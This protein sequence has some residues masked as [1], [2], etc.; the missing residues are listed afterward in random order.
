MP[1]GGAPSDHDQHGRDWSVLAVI[2]VVAGCCA[3]VL[4]A[5]GTGASPTVQSLVTPPPT[6]RRS[7][8]ISARTP[9][10]A[11]ISWFRAVQANDVRGVLALTSPGAQ[12]KVGR[13]VLRF[14]V[15]TVGRALGPPEVVRV[16]THASRATV[17]LLVIAQMPTSAQAGIEVPLTMSLVHAPSGWQIDDVAYL[18]A[19]AQAILRAARAGA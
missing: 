13:Q 6:A 16:V 15:E 9:Q 10:G 18:V 17:R 3:T 14:A 8:Q 19:S 7:P 1:D 2:A 4:I 12:R 11:L 5:V